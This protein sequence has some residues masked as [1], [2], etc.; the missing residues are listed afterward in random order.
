MAY[1]VKKAVAAGAASVYY[2]A[3]D[4]AGYLIGSTA[5]APAAGDANGSAMLQLEGVKNFPFSPNA[6]ERMNITGDDGAIAQFLWQPIELPTGDTTFA[7]SDQDFA[8]LAMSTKSHNIGGYQ[9]LGI[10]PGSVTYQDLCFLVTSQ[11]KSRTTG[12][13]GSSMFYSYLIMKANA[14]YQGR[15]VFAERGEAAF[16][17]NIIANKADAYPWGL[18]FSDETTGDTEFVVMEMT[19]AYRPII[20]RWTGDNDKTTFTL[21]KNIA[22]DSANNIAVYVDGVAA[23]YAADAPGASAFGVTESTTDS[24]VLGSAPGAGAKIVA[25]YG[26]S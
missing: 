18:A 21:A 5:T 11:S 9:F 19:S 7:V 10:Q 13:V 20:Q 14:F 6:P 8:A 15:D 22:E 23:T 3:V 2:G 26:W 16:V 17:Y 12:S 1:N 4:S 24:I 25:L